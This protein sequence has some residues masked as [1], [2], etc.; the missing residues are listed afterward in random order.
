MNWKEFKNVLRNNQGLPLQF[1][2]KQNQWVHNSFHITEIKEADIVS[3]DCGGQKN[4]WKE[5]VVQVWEPE[6]LVNGNAMAT[7]KAIEIIDR[8]ES[9]VK[10]DEGSEVKI[11]YGNASFGTRQMPVSS[12]QMIND[13]LVV[14]M[15]DDKTLCKAID[16][17]QTCGPKP[18]VRI[19]AVV[20]ATSENACAPG[21][22]CC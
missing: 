19:A 20:G 21:S 17:G 6:V 8:V 15:Q 13:H 16:R 11:E 14:Q 7:S 3:V 18:K 4:T 5:I 2:Y 22:G 1:E 12:F 10:M 9:I